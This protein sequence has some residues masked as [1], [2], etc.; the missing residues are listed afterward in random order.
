MNDAGTEAR[1]GSEAV[2]RVIKEVRVERRPTGKKYSIS[3]VESVEI[4]P[5]TPD[6]DPEYP[7]RGS[8]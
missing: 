5:V 7:N 6:D 8:G 4:I 1:R 3:E 2:R